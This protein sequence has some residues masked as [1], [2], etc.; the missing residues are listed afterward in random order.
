MKF[1]YLNSITF[2]DLFKL[3]GK[4]NLKD[5]KGKMGDCHKST[6]TLSGLN[7]NLLSEV[8]QYPI[9]QKNDQLLSMILLPLS[10]HENL[11]YKFVDRDLKFCPICVKNKYHS[12]LH[13]FSLIHHCPF[14]K[15]KLITQCPKCNMKFFYNLIDGPMKNNYNCNCGFTFTSENRSVKNNFSPNIVDPVVKKWI[16]LTPSEITKIQNCKMIDEYTL[17]FDNE[18]VHF[19]YNIPFVLNCLDITSSTIKLGENQDFLDRRLERERVKKVSF[20]HTRKHYQEFFEFRDVTYSYKQAHNVCN[21]IAR[22]LRKTVLKK[23]ICCIKELTR[24]KNTLLKEEFCPFAIAYVYWRIRLQGFKKYEYVDNWGITPFFK[25]SA[26]DYG[27]PVYSYKFE[28]WLRELQEENVVLPDNISSSRNTYLWV[29][30][31]LIKDLVIAEFYRCLDYGLN[32]RDNN[33]KNYT[34]SSI[35][36]LKYMPKLLIYKDANQYY[37]IKEAKIELNE[38]KKEI[39]KTT[40]INSNLKINRNR[41]KTRTEYGKEQ[42]FETRNFPIL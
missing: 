40:C 4:E 18:K 5:K 6:I 34:I 1:C 38:L 27:Y 8:L 31:H 3:Y 2:N 17:A 23:H 32:W 42:A 12:T 21:S 7:K 22:H 26:Q 10:L 37:F 20:L 9:H 14:H 29:V 33:K 24:Y 15:I 36:S 13:Q 25:D 19:S 30:N 28:E 39:T 16:T 11:N 41:K 35:Y